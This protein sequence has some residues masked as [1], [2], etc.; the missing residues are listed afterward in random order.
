MPRNTLLVI[1]LV[2]A[3][4]LV[5]AALISRTAP[6]TAASGS[7]GEQYQVIA[8]DKAFILYDTAD[9]KNS[10]VCFPQPDRKQNAWLPLKRIDTQA[11]A[12]N[13]KL[14]ENANK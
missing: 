3:G 9:S 8:N 2:A 11:D 4:A 12:Q 7:G 14:I 6:A 1:V 13:W 10:W 5:A